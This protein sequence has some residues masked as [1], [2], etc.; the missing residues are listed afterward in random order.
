MQAPL[1]IDT[2]TALLAGLS[3]RVFMRRHWQKKP[4]LIR[5]ALPG[6]APP[7]SR[8][9]LFALAEDEAVESRLVVRSGDGPGGRWSLRH[10]PLSRR[11]LPPVK[12]PGWTL[13]VQGLDLHLPAARELLDRFR[14]VPEARL[15]DLMLSWAS[16]GG[17]VGPHVDS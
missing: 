4:L 14:F 13:L 2:P 6:V 5:Q 10:G 7:L 12:R 1:D 9:A 3:P 17:G 11:A 8:A 16:E 15:D